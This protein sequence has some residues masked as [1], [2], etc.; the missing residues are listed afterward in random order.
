MAFPARQLISFERYLQLEEESPLKHEFLDGMA[1]AMA[2][3]TYD[4][5]AITTNVIVWLGQRLRG[6]G[7]RPYESNMRIRVKAT[8][9]ATY[10]DASIVC[11]RVQLDP[12]DP[13][14]TTVVNPRVLIEVLR[15]SA[16]KYDRGEKL[17]HYKKIATLREV[18]LISTDRRL[19]EVWRK[20]GHG[21]RRHEYRD[22]ADLASVDC[23]LPL[24]EV[25]RDLDGADS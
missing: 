1:W 22:V 15:P 13:K 10:P 14:S 18:A 25:Y 2:G 9:L 5:S 3:G 11:G 8:G 20:S 21:W 19:I 12:D 4:H 23:E 24:D 16:E 6:K 17:D 7:C